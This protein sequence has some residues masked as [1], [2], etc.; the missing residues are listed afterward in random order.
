MAQRVGMHLHGD[1]SALPAHIAKE[2]FV[3]WVVEKLVKVQYCVLYC[4][5][6]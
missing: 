3:T 1:I 6:S 5:S 4:F 2:S